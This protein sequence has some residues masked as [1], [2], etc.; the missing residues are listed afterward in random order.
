MCSSPPPRY[1]LPCFYST[2]FLAPLFAGTHEIPP[3]PFPRHVP[4][5][6]HP[7]EVAVTIAVMRR[8]GEAWGFVIVVII[9]AIIVIISQMRGAKLELCPSPSGRLTV[10]NSSFIHS[11]HQL[12][13][14]QR[15]P[16]RQE[17]APRVTAPLSPTAAQKTHHSALCLAVII[18]IIDVLLPSLWEWGGGQLV[19]MPV[20]TAAV[21]RCQTPHRRLDHVTNMTGRKIKRIYLSSRNSTTSR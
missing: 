19:I 3:P 14:G 4:P 7:E 16:E 10:T 18:I 15:R 12:Y 9:T 17:A 21:C 2:C 5:R 13:T 20:A 8:T 6:R 1:P 11:T